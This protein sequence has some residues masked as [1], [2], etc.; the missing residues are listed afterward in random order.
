MSSKS[1][2]GWSCWTV[3]ASLVQEQR[4]AGLEP[5]RHHARLLVT[6][7]VCGEDGHQESS[8]AST[9]ARPG[10]EGINQATPGPSARALNQGPR[11]STRAAHPSQRALK[12]APADDHGGQ[13]RAVARARI[14]P[15]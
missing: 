15:T 14:R 11:R 10:L 2:G 13:L 8:S 6:K 9:A 7:Y 1:R 4:Q 3:G 12:Q 5:T